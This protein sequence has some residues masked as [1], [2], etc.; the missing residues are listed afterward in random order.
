MAKRLNFDVIGSRTVNG[1]EPGGSFSVS[2][3]NVGAGYVGTKE[4]GKPALNVAALIL[5]G[6]VRPADEATEKWVYELGAGFESYAPK[7]REEKE[8]STNG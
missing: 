8:S 1:T 6:Y 4:E 3:S 2:E 5:S 7:E